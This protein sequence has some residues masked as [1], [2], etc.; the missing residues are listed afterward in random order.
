M[1]DR[2][3]TGHGALGTGIHPCRKS[4]G[5]HRWT[6]KPLILCCLLLVLFLI[7]TEFIYL[8]FWLM[9]DKEPQVEEGERVLR[10]E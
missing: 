2:I 10:D 6:S 9:T 1:W 3:E 5:W 7:L 4:I 8:I